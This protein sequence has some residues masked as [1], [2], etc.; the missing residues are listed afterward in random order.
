MRELRC[1]LGPTLINNDIEHQLNN[2]MQNLDICRRHNGFHILVRVSVS[3]PW[4]KTMLFSTISDRQ[5]V[6]C[7]FFSAFIKPKNLANGRNVDL[8]RSY[9]VHQ[10][11]LYYTVTHF[12]S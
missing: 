1:L 8:P 6:L 2:C 9:S 3:T 4:L 12:E 11:T 10:T 7:F 5:L